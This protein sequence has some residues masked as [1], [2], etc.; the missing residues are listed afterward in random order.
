MVSSQTIRNAVDNADCNAG[1]MKIP[2]SYSF[3]NLWTRRLTTALTMGGIALVVFVFAAVLMLS[4]G[5]HETLVST[6]SE[7]NAIVIRKSSESEIMSAVDRDAAAIIRSLPEIARLPDGTPFAC[8]E[9]NVIA[10]LLKIGSNDMANIVV[11]GTSTT[12]LPLRE[13]VSLI[14]GRMF[15]PGTSEVIVG[16]SIHERFQNCSIGRTLRFGGREWM[17]VGIFD[18]HHS[19]FDS[20]IWGDVEQL[21]PAFGRPVFS[22]MTVR[23]RSPQ[24]F[25]AFQAH[26][27]ADKRLQP[28]EAK[29]EKLFFEEQSKMMVTL[30]NVLGLIITTIF[31]IGAVVGAM[32]TMYAAVSNRTAEIG[33]LRALGFQR[34]SILAAFL[35]EALFISFFGGLAGVCLAAALQFITVSTLNYGSFS[36]VSFSFSLSTGI[37]AGSLL[38]SMGMGVAGGFLPAVRAAK[39]DIISA[40]RAA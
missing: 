3:R 15:R 25:D 38:F 27:S 9:V 1:V 33:T 35:F 4:N 36:E 5:L 32:I 14:N 12:G 18:G 30:I 21:M 10:N 37:I 29:R 22:A 20:E 40:L 7:K 28:F 19:G 24:E 16:K 31:S 17:I 6:G 11:R 34:I 8:P 39:M 26:F 23:L 2:L 13:Q